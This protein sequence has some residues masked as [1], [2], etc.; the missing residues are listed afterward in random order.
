MT[1]EHGYMP[2]E[3]GYMLEERGYMPEDRVMCIPEKCGY[4][5]DGPRLNDAI[6]LVATRSC[7]QCQRLVHAIHLDQQIYNA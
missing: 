7:L 6:F 4:M 2:E 1:E 3:R 5:L